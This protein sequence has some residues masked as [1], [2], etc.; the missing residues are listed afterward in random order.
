M[1]ATFKCLCTGN[2]KGNSR[3]GDCYVYSLVPKK[4]YQLRLI[5]HIERDQQDTIFIYA[6][7][8]CNMDKGYLQEL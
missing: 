3:P 6:F 5:V 8:Y 2:N 4:L 1:A 7:L